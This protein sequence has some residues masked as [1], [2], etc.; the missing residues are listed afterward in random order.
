VTC[1]AGRGSPLSAE[2]ERRLR[3]ALG[4]AAPSLEATGRARGAA[5]DAIPRVVAAPRRRRLRPI[6]A[7]ALGAALVAGVAVA[8]RTVVV[9]SAPPSAEPASPILEPR[10]GRAV[11]A[12]DGT[13]AWVAA[14]DGT[15]FS[16]PATAVTISPAGLFAAFGGRRELVVT[17]MDGDVRWRRAVPGTV[18]AISW[19]P[20]PTYIAY[21]VRRG[22]RHDIR[23]IWA[24]GR[25]DRLFATG[26]AAIPPRWSAD[27]ESL[28]YTTAEGRGVTRLRGGVL[29]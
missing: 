28:T 14:P 13:R 12:L 18:V 15:R 5:L 2:L 16:R 19:A 9:T 25:N 3:A 4:S 10:N 11:A 17:E 27:T 21:L 7:V 24:N 1:A 22:S 6:V 26:V 8:A 23:L 20:Y 29:P